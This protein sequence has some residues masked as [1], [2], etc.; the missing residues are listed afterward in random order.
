MVRLS[1]LYK[2]KKREDAYDDD[3]VYEVKRHGPK[4]CEFSFIGSDVY[5]LRQIN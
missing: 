4:V 5:S 2:R 3:D 1:V